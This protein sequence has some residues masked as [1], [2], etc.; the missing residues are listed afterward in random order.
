MKY[1]IKTVDGTERTIKANRFCTEKNFIYF[2]QGGVLA[3]PI[4]IFSVFTII[5]IEVV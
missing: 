1:L 3:D 5:S 2:Y 4:A